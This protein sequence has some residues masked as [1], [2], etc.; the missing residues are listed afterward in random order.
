MMNR[1]VKTTGTLVLAAALA[2]CAAT[3]TITTTKNDS[4]V[5]VNAVPTYGTDQAIVDLLLGA[6]DGVHEVVILRGATGT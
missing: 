3:T 2:G 1:A 4:K 5:F 6:F